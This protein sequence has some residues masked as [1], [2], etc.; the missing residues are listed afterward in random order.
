MFR[1]KK[2]KKIYWAIIKNKPQK[3]K[4]I[5]IHYLLKNNAKNKS[6]AFIKKCKNALRSELSYELIHSLDNYHLLEVSPKT[7]DIIKLEFN[8]PKLA[9]L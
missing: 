8:L 1:E 7:E 6:H 2:V 4:N 3:S 9:A 5:L